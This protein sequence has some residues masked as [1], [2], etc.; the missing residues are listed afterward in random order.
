VLLTNRNAVLPIPRT[1]RKLAIIGGNADAGV[2]SGGGSSRVNPVGG[3]ARIIPLGGDSLFRLAAAMLFDP[4][5]PQRAIQDKVPGA[6][7]HFNDGRYPKAAADLARTADYAIVFAT[8]WMSEEQD[9]PDLSLPSGQEQL[10][11]AVSK[12]NS[13]TIVVLETGGSVIMPWLDRVAAV[14]EAWYPGARGG[15]AIANVLFGDINPSGR[16]PISFPMSETQL[17]RPNIVGTDPSADTPIVVDYSVGASVG[18]RSYASTRQEP[19]FPFGFGL[20]YTNFRYSRLE[21]TDGDTLT[22]RFD[23]EN[24][25]TLTGVDVPQV[26]LTNVDGVQK[27]RLIGWA[28]LS[29]NPGQTHRVTVTDDPGLLAD[30]DTTAHAWRLGPGTYEVAV[31]NSSATPTLRATGNLVGQMIKP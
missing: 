14:L 28:R 2:L 12:A 25:G 4:S 18:Y 27:I 26:Y 10:I 19:L 5:S 1:A 24:T 21:I 11:E 3:P 20:S 7:L 31:S 17:L 13:R 22:I 15:E 8:Q 30:F 9:A 16:L 23:V 6:E 29:L